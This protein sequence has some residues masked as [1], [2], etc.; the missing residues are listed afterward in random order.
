M[1]CCDQTHQQHKEG[2]HMKMDQRKIL[3]VILITLHLSLPRTEG[4]GKH[5]SDDDQAL[6]HNWKI[7]EWSLNCVHVQHQ[8]A[9]QF[10]RHISSLCVSSLAQSGAPSAV[11]S[12]THN[13]GGN[14]EI[15]TVLDLELN[16]LSS[17]GLILKFK[18]LQ[19]LHF[20]DQQL[21]NRFKF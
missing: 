5:V 14:G 1:T 19:F 20:R 4:Q 2:V 12:Q 18:R 11:V 10:A 13:D 3:Q 17:S 8:G 9:Q 16:W 21:V 6:Y 7:C 15:M